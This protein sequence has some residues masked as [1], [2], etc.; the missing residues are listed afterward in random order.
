M[1][2][3]SN[4]NNGTDAAGAEGMMISGVLECWTEGTEVDAMG[5]LLGGM[6]I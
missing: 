1:E 4:G 2:K 6:M 3:Q 5:Y